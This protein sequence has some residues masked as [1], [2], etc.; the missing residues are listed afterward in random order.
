MQT[1]RQTDKEKLMIALQNFAKAPKGKGSRYSLSI[2]DS[3][4]KIC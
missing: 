4:W 1:D 2:R 3:K